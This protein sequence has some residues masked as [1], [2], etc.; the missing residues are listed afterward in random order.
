MKK[1]LIVAIAAIVLFAIAILPAAAGWTW[2]S[3]DPHV[4]LPD[5]SLVQLWVAVPEGYENETVELQ[6]WAPEGSQVIGGNGRLDVTVDLRV[7]RAT[8]KIK[9]TVREDFPVQINAKRHGESLGEFTF[10]SGKGVAIWTW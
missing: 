8:D 7:L 6:V 2:C 9:L 10:D 4:K 1:L 3:T 5:N